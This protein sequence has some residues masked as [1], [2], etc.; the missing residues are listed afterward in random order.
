MTLR[1]YFPISVLA[2]IVLLVALDYTSIHVAPYAMLMLV[3]ETWIGL[4]LENRRVPKLVREILRVP[5]HQ[6]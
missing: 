1:Q 3:I 5:K 6:G 4:E 2:F